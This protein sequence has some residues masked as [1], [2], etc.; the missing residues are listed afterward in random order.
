M[1][2]VAIHKK[3]GGLVEVT[4]SWIGLVIWLQEYDLIPKGSVAI[5]P[6]VIYH[7]DPRFNDY[8]IIGSL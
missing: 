1:A 5:W 2:L 7:D 4:K 8:E 6:Y 3:E